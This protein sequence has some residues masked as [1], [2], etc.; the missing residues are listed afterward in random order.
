LHSIRLDSVLNYYGKIVWCR[1]WMW[2][3]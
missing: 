1:W 3:C 2:H